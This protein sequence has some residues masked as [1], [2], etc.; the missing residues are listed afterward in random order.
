MTDTERR[1]S[2]DRDERAN[3]FRTVD[4][5]VVLYDGRNAEAWIQSSYVVDVAGVM[6]SEDA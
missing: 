6:E 2:A 5:D 1:P 4:G 3:A